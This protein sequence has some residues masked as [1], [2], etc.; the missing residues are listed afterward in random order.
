MIF[1]LFAAAFVVA[2][3]VPETGLSQRISLVGDDLSRYAEGDVTDTNSVGLRLASWK[4]SWEMAK[5]HLF[6]GIG[7]GGYRPAI[8]RMVAEGR[9][10]YDT[11]VY[12]TQPHSIYFAVLVDC[13]IPGLVCLLAVFLLPIKIFITRTLKSE[14]NREAAYAGLV[15][16]VS[17]IHFGLTETVFGRNLFVA[18]YVILLS[19]ILF[20][21]RETK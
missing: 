13:G 1:A 20:L 16:A 10:P 8:K 9:L 6:L 15:L 12:Y 17:Y 11:S 14:G 3:Q 21:T 19:M 7:P 18:F 2:Y 4:A 5:D